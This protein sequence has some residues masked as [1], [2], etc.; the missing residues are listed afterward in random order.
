M[1]SLPQTVRPPRTRPFRLFSIRNE[2][3]LVTELFTDWRLET[4]L[5]TQKQPA[6]GTGGANPGA[7]AGGAYA[8]ADNGLLGGNGLDESYDPAFANGN[9]AADGY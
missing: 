9:G 5:A 1:P 3:R 6:P 2:K 7:S 4:L 8:D